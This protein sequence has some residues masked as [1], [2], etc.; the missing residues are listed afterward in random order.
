MYI[1]ICIWYGLCYASYHN[2]NQQIEK[3][4]AHIKHHNNYNY[5]YGPDYLDI[6]FNT[7]IGYK[8]ENMNSGIINNILI[9]FIISI[10]LKINPIINF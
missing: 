9:C 1:N 2:I 7:K 6:F 10:L 8:L 3:P 4:E 5:N